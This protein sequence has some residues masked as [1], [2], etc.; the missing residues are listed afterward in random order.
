MGKGWAFTHPVTRE[1]VFAFE[2]SLL[3]NASTS[4]WLLEFAPY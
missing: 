1:V 3:K 2:G 4:A